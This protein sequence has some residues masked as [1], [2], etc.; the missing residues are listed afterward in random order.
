MDHHIKIV[1]HDRD[2]SKVDEHEQIMLATK[3]EER[4]IEKRA[5]S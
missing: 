4:S 1:S 2:Y 5:E 3:N